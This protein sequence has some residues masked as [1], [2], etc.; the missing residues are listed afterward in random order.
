MLVENRIEND[1]LPAIEF[2]LGC[3]IIYKHNIIDECHFHPKD[4]WIKLER[5]KQKKAFYWEK[6]TAIDQFAKDTTDSP[7]NRIDE[8]KQSKF[9]SL[10]L[11]F[12]H[13]STPSS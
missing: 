12:Y 5:T 7:K 11:F 13:K 9:L 10:S 3:P 4:I 8:V 2:P 1:H 6:R